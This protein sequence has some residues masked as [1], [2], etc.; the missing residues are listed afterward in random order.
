M[1]EWRLWGHLW[2]LQVGWIEL[3]V[4]GMLCK[5][6]CWTYF[7]LKGQFRH[8]RELQWMYT[9]KYLTLGQIF[10]S[11]QRDKWQ[12][13]GMCVL[14]ANKVPEQK[15]RKRCSLNAKVFTPDTFVTFSAGAVHLCQMNK[16]L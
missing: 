10:V 5:S 12:S 6:S 9:N 16:M 8:T 13:L 3:C 4:G 11:L 2:W 1:W 14:A 15:M 7:N